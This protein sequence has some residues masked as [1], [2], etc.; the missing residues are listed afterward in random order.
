MQAQVDEAAGNVPHHM[1]E[2]AVADDVDVEDMAPLMEGNGIHRL[3]RI[4]GRRI[5]AFKSRKIMRPQE[6]GR[7]FPHGLPVQGLADEPGIAQEKGVMHAVVVDG[8]AVMLAHI[9]VADA[10]AVGH[11]PGRQD[12]NFR[13][14]I[15]FHG[16]G[17]LF[18]RNRSLTI[19]IDDLAAGVDTGIRAGGAINRNR[20]LENSRQ[21]LFDAAL[22]RLGVGLALEAVEIRTVIGDDEADILLHHNHRI[23]ARTAVTIRTAAMAMPS[24]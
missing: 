7:P 16:I 19:E 8:I 1:V 23:A 24:R 11:F 12:G 5:L 18:R 13:R 17:N 6:D 9:I 21:A 20:R 2:E 4:H 10:E 22:D 14:Q 15:A 3:H